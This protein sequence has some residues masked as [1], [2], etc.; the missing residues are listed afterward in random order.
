[1]C[2]WGG[3]IEIIV[4]TILIIYLLFAST[5]LGYYLIGILLA[6]LCQKEIWTLQRNSC[7]YC[8]IFGAVWIILACVPVNHWIMEIITNITGM[9]FLWLLTGVKRFTRENRLLIWKSYFWIYCGHYLLLETIEKLWYLMAGDHV[10]CAL[11]DVLIAP[12]IVLII[13]EIAGKLLQKLCP[14]M[15]RVAIGQR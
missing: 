6:E 4:Y 3:I 13:L 8:W 11:I 9:I 1:M 14:R 2:A 7:N 10:W 5:S 12:G 15:W